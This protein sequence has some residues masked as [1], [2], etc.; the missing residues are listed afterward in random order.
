MI[1]TNENIA[2]S[3]FHRISIG[4]VLSWTK[5]ASSMN[6]ANA[7]VAATTTTM[8]KHGTRTRKCHHSDDD[9]D[10]EDA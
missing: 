6:V 5:V 4:V 2:V 7:V 3:N 1:N 10:D 8:L 9:D